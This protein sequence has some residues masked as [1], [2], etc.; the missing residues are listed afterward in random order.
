MKA[1]SISEVATSTIKRCA[2]FIPELDKT[3]GGGFANGASYLI[4]GSPGVGKS[5]ILMQTVAA[6]SDRHKPLYISGEE[7][8][9]QVANRA[10]R[11]GANDGVLVLATNDFDVV[12]EQIEEAKPTFIVL[13]SAQTVASKEFNGHQGSASQVRG[14]GQRITTVCKD[15]G[16]TLIIVAQRTKD[17]K[18]AGPKEVEHLVDCVLDFEHEE[19]K[20]VLIPVKNRLAATNARGYFEMKDEGLISSPPKKADVANEFLMKLM[21]GG[22]DVAKKSLTKGL[23]KLITSYLPKP[24][25]KR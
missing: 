2:T 21:S 14:V 9:V 24:K 23:D 20:R 8:A 3:L 12:L 4:S 22:M 15:R 6:V 16:I 13:D 5:T 1:V 10:K 17:N 25:R 11:L 18:I 19:G 7:S